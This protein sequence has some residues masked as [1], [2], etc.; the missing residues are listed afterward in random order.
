MRLC[1][2]VKRGPVRVWVVEKPIKHAAIS[3]GVD[4]S[5]TAVKTAPAGPLPVTVLSGFLGAGDLKSHAEEPHEPPHRRH[6]E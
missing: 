1:R 2:G 4:G 5:R 6:C 3:S